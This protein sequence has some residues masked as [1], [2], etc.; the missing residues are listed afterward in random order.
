MTTGWTNWLGDRHCD[1]EVARPRS[2]EELQQVVR[3]A[4]REGRRI[5]PAGAGYSWSPLVSDAEFLVSMCNLDQPIR[6]IEAGERTVEVQC[7]M[8]IG[9]LTTLTRKAGFTPISPTLFPKPTIGG[10]IATGSHG[11]GIK[12]GNFGD[13]VL[14]MT[15]VRADGSLQVIGNEDRDFRAAQVALGTLGILYSVKLRVEPQFNVYTDKRLV[16]VH[17]VLEE[18][19]DLIESYEFVEILWFPQQSH[20]WL[21]LM[22]RTHSRA[23]PP[24]FWSS[25]RRRLDAAVENTAA[26]RLIPWVASHAPRLTPFL[27]RTASAL[28]N[29]V[30]A[31][32]Q[33][34]SDAFHFQRVYPKNWDCCYVVPAEHA[35]RAWSEAIALVNEYARSEQYPV[36]LALHC[37][38]TGRSDAWLAPNYGRRSLWIEVATARATPHWRPFFRSM[39][40]RWFAIPDARPHWSK[41]YDPWRDIASRYPRLRDFLAVRERWDPDRVFLNPFLENA[42]FRLPARQRFRPPPAATPY[43]TAP[44]PPV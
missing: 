24:R 31:S 34:A 30:K 39:E 5:R 3:R 20:M 22:D 10:V 40:E 15:I 4:A 44:P 28:S 38:F 14:E 19:Q 9:K 2:L 27:N 12:T 13:Q 43:T 11:T 36:N 41:V 7:G 37:R 6:P 26:N 33:T 17:Y 18:F 1:C 29:Q 8:T 42:I 25:L 32:V 35:T 16:P 23:D 21:Y